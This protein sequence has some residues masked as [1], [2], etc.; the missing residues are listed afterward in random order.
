MLK[1]ILATALNTLYPPLCFHCQADWSEGPLCSHCL[2][3]LEVVDP[4]TRC[5]YCFSSHV[6]PGQGTCRRC[7]LEEPVLDSFAAVFDYYG[8]V[9]SLISQFKYS[10]KYWLAEGLAAYMAAQW[11][12]LDWPVPDLIVPVPIPWLRR[13][14]RGYNQSALLAKSLSKIL[15]A[16]YAMCLSRSVGDCS[17]ASLSRSLRKKLDGNTFRLRR[18]VDDKTVLLID[19]VFTTGQTLNCCAEKLLEGCPAK[20]YG[21]SLA[22]A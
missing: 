8:P 12:Q 14:D 16:P 15:N 9:T 6:N 21:L 20:I 10:G 22:A 18:S 3:L 4:A 1:S 17:Q 2:S 7:I 5:R 11:V 13:I 19:D